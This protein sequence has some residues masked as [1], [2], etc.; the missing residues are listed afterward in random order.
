MTLLTLKSSDRFVANS[1][2]IFQKYGV[3][4]EVGYDFDEYHETLKTARPDQPLGA[5]FDPGIHDL[6]ASNALWVI[7][8]KACGEVIHTQA[9]RMLDMQG[10]TVAEYFTRKFREFPPAVPGVD[11][12]RS[13]F[14]AGPYAKRSRGTV[15]YNGEFWIKPGEATFRGQGLSCVLGRY[16]FF[17]AM[18]HWNPDY[19]VG[20]MAQAVACKGFPQRLGWMHAQPG[21]LRWFLEGSDT[22]ME[23]FMTF[24]DREDLH[25]VLELPLKDLVAMAA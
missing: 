2:E 1:A 19:M 5:P 11:L 17:Q 22:P 10:R 15:C 24:M 18:Q 25:Y 20:F 9:L 3:R 6:S 8:R 13:R 12:K 14:R 7:G 21:A 23:G 4:L 16:A